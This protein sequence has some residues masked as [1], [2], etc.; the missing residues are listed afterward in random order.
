MWHFEATELC[1]FYK[2]NALAANWKLDHSNQFLA[3]QTSENILCCGPRSCSGLQ[4]CSGLLS[5]TFQGLPY[6]SNSGFKR[7][8]MT[9]RKVRGVGT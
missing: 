5:S 3:Y 2:N 7:P 6:I 9:I 1:R 4:T 8:R